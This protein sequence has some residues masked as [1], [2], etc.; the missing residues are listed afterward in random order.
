MTRSS[1]TTRVPPGKGQ[2][3]GEKADLQNEPQ[4][5]NLRGLTRRVLRIDYVYEVILL[6][7][8][9]EEE[10]GGTDKTV[11]IESTFPLISLRFLCGHIGA[12]GEPRGAPRSLAIVA[13]STS[14]QM[15]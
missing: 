13:A 5:P 7:E 6:F 8:G 11:Y 1:S 3:T 2:T 14:V 15:N 10:R 9:E 12:L 4:S